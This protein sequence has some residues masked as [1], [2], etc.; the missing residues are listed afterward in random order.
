[1]TQSLPPQVHKKEQSTSTEDLSPINQPK[2][3]KELSTTSRAAETKK[4]TFRFIKFVTPFYF[5]PISTEAVNRELLA[6]LSKADS[7]VSA[8]ELDIFS[9]L[10]SEKQSLQV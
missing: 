1:M 4:V 2:A 7:S 6:R 9:Q 3:S 5:Q 10:L 8:E